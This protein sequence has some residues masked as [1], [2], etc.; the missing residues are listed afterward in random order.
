M[1]FTY[2]IH[3]LVKRGTDRI[4]ITT[5]IRRALANH[6]SSAPILTSNYKRTSGSSVDAHVTDYQRVYDVVNQSLR[7][8]D[9]E[10]SYTT[11]EKSTFSS[12]T[13][14]HATRL[15]MYYVL[16]TVYSTICT[17]PLLFLS[18]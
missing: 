16:Y 18:L 3:Y 12:A 5:M 4:N 9:I 6:Y 14:Y 15:C 1:Q 8:I 2:N 7:N 13:N 10:Y 17:V 11:V